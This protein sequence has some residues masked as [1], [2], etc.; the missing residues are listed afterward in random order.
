MRFE[1][2]PSKSFPG[3]EEAV[4]ARSNRGIQRLVVVPLV[5]DVPLNRWR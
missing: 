5:F 2:L 1:V 3:W 4:H